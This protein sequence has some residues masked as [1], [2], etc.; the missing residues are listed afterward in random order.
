MKKNMGNLDRIV[1]ALIALNILFFY[2]RGFLP[3]SIGIVLLTLAGIFLVT[4]LFAYCPL[5]TIFSIHTN[6]GKSSANDN[7]T[8]S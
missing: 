2:S 3:G 8:T 5:Y 4:S 1:R 7:K 6:K